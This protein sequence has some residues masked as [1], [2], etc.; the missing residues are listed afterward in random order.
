MDRGLSYYQ[1]EYKELEN[2][3]MVNLGTSP[4]TIRMG[5]QKVGGWM[6]RNNRWR[7]WSLLLTSRPLSKIKSNIINGFMGMV[8]PYWNPHYKKWDNY[9]SHKWHQ[10]LFPIYLIYTRFLD[11]PSH[12][13]P[14]SSPSHIHSSLFG[15]TQNLEGGF[16]KLNYS[17]PLVSESCQS[18]R[19]SI[20]LWG[21]SNS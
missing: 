13:S 14:R 16:S 17:S 19:L 15:F 2:G 21:K 8:I 5:T 10:N 9:E 6:G 3:K 12:H 20:S 1:M 11:P 18:F 4:N 7:E